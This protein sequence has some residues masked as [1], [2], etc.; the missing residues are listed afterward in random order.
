VSL[1]FYF[2]RNVPTLRFKANK[3]YRAGISQVLLP[4]WYDCYDYATRVEYL[5]IGIYGNKKVAPNVEKEEFSNAVLGVIG[6]KKGVDTQF[7]V[8]AKGLR[9]LCRRSGGRKRVAEMISELVLEGK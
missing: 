2:Y 7:S 9:V 8:K 6:E 4:A 5:G 1:L 3:L